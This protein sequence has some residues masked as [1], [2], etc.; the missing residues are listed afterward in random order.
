M[1]AYESVVAS[2]NPTHFWSLQPGERGTDDSY[3]HQ[4]MHG[5]V[6]LSGN[7]TYNS[8]E[9]MWPGPYGLFGATGPAFLYLYEYVGATINANANT[10]AYSYG[11]WFR[12]R[13]LTEEIAVDNPTST[14]WSRRTLMGNWDTNGSM[15]HTGDNSTGD[16]SDFSIYH[17]SNI[18]QFDPPES[19]TRGDWFHIIVTWDGATQRVYWNGVLEG[20]VARTGALG[21]ATVF[22]VGT[23]NS[24]TASASYVN[25]A[26]VGWWV[27]KTLSAHE[28]KRL[29][30]GVV[31][32]QPSP[33]T[34]QTSAA[35]AVDQPTA[36]QRIRTGISI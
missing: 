10:T 17:E 18:Y 30:T 27:N 4:P 26:W 25:A 5:G 16:N 28:V 24:S 12:H 7:S 36:G 9:P 8:Q 19:Y 11:G 15:I 32:T 20:S 22:H 29:Y 21:A 33:S 2:T 3:T 34:I 1:T 6:V 23:Y 31:R 14:Q 13:T 35:R